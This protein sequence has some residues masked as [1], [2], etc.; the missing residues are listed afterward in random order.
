MAESAA[1]SEDFEYEQSVG[2]SASPLKKPEASAPGPISESKG[3]DSRM[4][5]V[6]EESADVSVQPSVS[7]SKMEA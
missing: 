6:K 3:S 2:Q 1:Y 5:P 7:G 4:E